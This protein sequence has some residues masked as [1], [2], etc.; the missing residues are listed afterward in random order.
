MKKDPAAV[1]L[2]KRGA[3]KRN[4]N[5]SPKQKSDAARNAANKRWA[6]V[7][8]AVP[9]SLPKAYGKK[10]GRPGEERQMNGVKATRKEW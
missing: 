1:N 10:G 6:K 3:A 2:G 7:W 8:L 9:K 4:A 5:M